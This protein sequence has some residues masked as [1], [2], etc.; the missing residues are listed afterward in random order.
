MNE[1]A[2]GLRYWRCVFSFLL[3]FLTAFFGLGIAVAL[4][5][6]R[7]VETEGASFNFNLSGL[8][9]VAFFLLF[10]GYFIIFNRFLGGTIW[11]RIL[12]VGPR[13]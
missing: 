11:R 7:G 4:F 1:Q 3:D 8:S 9:A 12:G 2:S 5:S 6:G 10:F 13:A